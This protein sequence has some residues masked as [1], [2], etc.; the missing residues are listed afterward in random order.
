MDGGTDDL[1]PGWRETRRVGVPVSLNSSS[2]TR[3]V[4]S[5]FLVNAA[6]T[7]YKTLLH[8]SLV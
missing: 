5:F 6:T 1:T 8:R 4:N 7:I 3:R 2:S